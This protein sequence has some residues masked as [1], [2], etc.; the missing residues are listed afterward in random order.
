MR[1]LQKRFGQRPRSF[2]EPVFR[3]GAS[4]YLIVPGWNFGAPG[5]FN[6]AFTVAHALGGR[7]PRLTNK[8]DEVAL[9]E[10]VRPTFDPDSD[11]HGFPIDASDRW[12]EGIWESYERGVTLP[13][14]NWAENEPNDMK[15]VEDFGVATPEG[16][17]DTS[18]YKF[19]EEGLVFV[20]EWPGD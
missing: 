4:H 3:I 19:G 10:K 20:I 7:F 2:P 8:S 17:N 5:G 16:W 6:Q 15:G 18:S 12:K 13:Y 11:R 14:T 1:A 9:M